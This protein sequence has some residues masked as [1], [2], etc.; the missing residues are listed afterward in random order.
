MKL[1]VSY[2]AEFFLKKFFGEDLKLSW[3]F[4]YEEKINKIK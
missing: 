4:E 3:S 2:K 1:I